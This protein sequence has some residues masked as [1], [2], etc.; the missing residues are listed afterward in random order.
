MTTI[1]I[2][3]A[4]YFKKKDG[5]VAVYLF[6]PHAARS[7]R[8]FSDVDIGII[9][10]HTDV[11]GIKKRFN[12]YIVDLGRILRK[13]VHPVMLN[14]AS[15]CLLSQVFEKGQC[16]VINNRHALSEFRMT[17]LARIAEFSYY[18]DKMQRGF[19]QGIVEA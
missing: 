18:K 9:A 5:V 13:D 3:I 2:E 8:P 17:R 12:E 1:Q 6:G 16:L 19:V 14:L 11:Y 15:E 4:D 7:Q 10:E